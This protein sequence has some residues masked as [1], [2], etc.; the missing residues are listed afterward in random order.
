MKKKELIK[1]VSIMPHKVNS[2]FMIENK[3]GNNL[4]GWR[5]KMKK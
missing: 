5:K 1:C 3:E 4:K 2:F